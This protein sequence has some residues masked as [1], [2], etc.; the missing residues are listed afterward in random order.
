M[1]PDDPSQAARPGAHAPGFLSS[2]PMAVVNLG[3]QPAVAHADE[4]A[5]RSRPPGLRGALAELDRILRGEVTSVSALSRDGI[6]VAPGRLSA[7]IVGLSMI[8]GVCMG[9]FAVFRVKSPSLSQ[10]VASMIKV[11]L[12]FYLTLLV[13]MPS[14]YVFNALVGSRLRLAAIVRL[15]IASL[16][17]TI[18]VLA[19][20]GPIVAFFSVTTTSY[21]FIVLFNVVVFS[22]SGVLGL[23]FLLQTLQRLS[24]VEAQIRPPAPGAPAS[25]HAPEPEQSQEAAPSAEP[26]SPLDPLGDRALSKHV[27]VVFRVWVIVFALVGAQMGWV[28]RPFIGSPSM[29]FVWLRGRESNF[30]QAVLRHIASLFS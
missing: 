30:F 3:R 18:A 17:V 7:V 14:L 1:I 10:A 27:K 23:M 12:L 16:G 20:L 28:L 25:P 2:P 8:Y 22:I 6:S 19:S 13:T 24:T 11:P 9:M 5:A 29:P 26:R 4:K 15:L 21:S